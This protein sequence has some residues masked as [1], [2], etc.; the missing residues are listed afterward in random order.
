MLHV[1]R[2]T[3]D[4]HRFGEFLA[5]LWQGPVPADLV[6]HRWLYLQGQP[7]S[8]LMLWE[9]DGSAESYVERVFGSFGTLD[10]EPVTDATP[11]LAACFARDLEGFGQYL[12][13]ERAADETEVRVQLDVRRRGMAAPTFEAAAAAGRAWQAE[14][15]R[16]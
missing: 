7:R 10:T 1:S 13:S 9:G 11:G 15:D 8:M 6:L 14:R 12:R 3:P 5:C 4:P 2:F 16:S